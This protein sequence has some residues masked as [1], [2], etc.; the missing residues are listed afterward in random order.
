MYPRPYSARLES[1]ELPQAEL[2]PLIA[3]TSIDEDPGM[4][5]YIRLRLRHS[6]ATNADS[7]HIQ[8]DAFTALRFESSENSMTLL[9]A[10]SQLTC[11]YRTYTMTA[12]LPDL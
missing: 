7:R 5:V 6:Y 3:P 4:R 12:S 9:P 11:S 10:F 1:T 2:S 8:S